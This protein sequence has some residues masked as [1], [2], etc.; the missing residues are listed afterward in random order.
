MDDFKK[1]DPVGTILFVDQ[2]SALVPLKKELRRRNHL[3]LE[4]PTAETAL[5]ALQHF[6]FDLTVIDLLIPGEVSGYHLC[7]QFKQEEA[8]RSIPVFLFCNHA[9]PFSVTRAYL[10][11]LKAE[12]LIIPPFDLTAICDRICRSLRFRTS[13]PF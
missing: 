10:S 11:E 8:T 13:G 12:Y 3:I 7:K 4:C 9:L 5:S 2:T 1:T 6:Q